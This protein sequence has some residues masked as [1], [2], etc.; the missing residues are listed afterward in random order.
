M[1]GAGILRLCSEI[2]CISTHLI[3]LHVTYKKVLLEHAEDSLTMLCCL[4]Y[5]GLTLKMKDEDSV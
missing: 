3:M 1:L 2:T 5:A 4:H